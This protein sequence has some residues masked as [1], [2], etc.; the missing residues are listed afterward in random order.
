MKVKNVAGFTVIF[1][2]LLLTGCSKEKPGK[3]NG[4]W[5]LMKMQLVS[6]NGEQIGFPVGESLFLF[7]KGYY[8]ITYA[9]GRRAV[10][11]QERWHPTDN[12]KLARFRSVIVNTGRYRLEGTKLL[13][14]PL[15]ALAPEFIGGK[16]VFSYAFTGDTLDL[17]WEQSI[18]FDGLEYPTG[19]TVTRLRLVPIP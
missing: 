16:G 13:L 14:E 1:S 4:A 8:S 9:F 12:E 3:L 17:T 10:P 18:A 6:A 2:A 15:F 19:G 7:D 11:Y 5:Q